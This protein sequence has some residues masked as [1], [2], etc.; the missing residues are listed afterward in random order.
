MPSG[1]VTITY[2][3]ADARLLDC[4]IHIAK[5]F[6][7]RDK[8]KQ[9]R[10]WAKARMAADNERRRKTTEKSRKQ[11]IRAGGVKQV[12]ITDQKGDINARG[13]PDSVK[14][15]QGGRR[16]KPLGVLLDLFYAIA[17]AVGRAFQSQ[18][19]YVIFWKCSELKKIS[20]G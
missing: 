12:S 7:I 17:T 10:H 20:V 5:R 3:R 18:V 6:E 8:L 16:Q 11:Q 4:V 14:K 1:T 13:R 19:R 9:L 2:V 15:E